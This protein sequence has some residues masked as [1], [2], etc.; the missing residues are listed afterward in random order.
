MPISDVSKYRTPCEILR[1]IND[2]AQGSL[3]NDKKIRELACELEVM[4]KKLLPYV[5]D[6]DYEPNPNQLKDLCRRALPTYK[7][8][9]ETNLRMD[10]CEEGL[11]VFRC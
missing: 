7:Y 3:P 9:G 2:N 1:E 6:S 8:E 10:E 5:V 4:L 11:K